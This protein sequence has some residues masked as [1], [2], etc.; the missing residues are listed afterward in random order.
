MQVGRVLNS[1]RCLQ[2]ITV[3][4]LGNFLGKSCQT[5][6]VHQFTH[7]TFYDMTISRIF[8]RSSMFQT[9]Q[10]VTKKLTSG[11]SWQGVFFCK[12]GF[13]CKQLASFVDLLLY[14]S[15]W[16]VVVI[17]WFMFF[18]C[19]LYN[20]LCNKRILHKLYIIVTN[21]NLVTIPILHFSK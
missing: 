1:Q 8:L 13:F 21:F 5:A 3:T 17:S 4:F 9:G 2:Y 20:I 6:A 16:Q 11:T 15:G 19:L 12:T 18:S 10:V 14:N 7:C